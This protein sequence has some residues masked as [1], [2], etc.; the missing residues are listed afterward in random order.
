MSASEDR[1]AKT[2]MTVAAPSYSR[3]EVGEH[4]DRLCDGISEVAEEE[5]YYLG[6]GG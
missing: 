6:R 1:E 5:R 3:M 4:S 2:G